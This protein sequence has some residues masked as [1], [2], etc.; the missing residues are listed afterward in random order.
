MHGPCLVEAYKRLVSIAQKVMPGKHDAIRSCVIHA[1]L[2]ILVC[3]HAEH[4]Y[5]TMM[6]TC[7][8]SAA[9]HAS[10][11][12]AAPV[13]GEEPWWHRVPRDVGVGLRA[14]DFADPRPH[15]TWKESKVKVET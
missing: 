4:M 3:N 11:L 2:G 14:I 13:H 8:R 12:S 15:S 5:A 7:M 6:S 1:S 9:G 10:N